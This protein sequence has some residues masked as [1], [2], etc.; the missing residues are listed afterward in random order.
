MKATSSGPE[1]P[2]KQPVEAEAN[3]EASV[4][5]G[6]HEADTTTDE[7]E[8]VTTTDS[9]PS[10][11]VVNVELRL[12]T[13]TLTKQMTHFFQKANC[14]QL[15]SQKKLI[16][17]AD[18]RKGR[19]PRRFGASEIEEPS[20]DEAKQLA[21]EFSLMVQL[22]K[23]KARNR[24]AFVLF[25]ILVAGAVTALLYFQNKRVEE[26]QRIAAERRATATQY[27]PPDDEEQ[28]TYAVP[29]NQTE[30]NEQVGNSSA[31]TFCRRGRFRRRA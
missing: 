16:L 29:A 21:Q 11:N 6:E 10:E 14:K 8:A 1:T 19:R 23:N 18:G 20:R 28:P 2:T 7:H 3:P 15:L 13:M 25:I 24:T 5:T 12:T 27:V 31:R 30:T 22:N 9:E 26:Q 17:L 4:T